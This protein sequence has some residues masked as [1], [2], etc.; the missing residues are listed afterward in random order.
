MKWNW[1]DFF[2]NHIAVKCFDDFITKSM[3][4]RIVPMS[5]KVKSILINR[6]NLAVHQPGEVVFYRIKEKS[7]I[8]KQLASNSKKL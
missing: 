2:Q 3:K 8:K 1:I 6:F 4:E 7:F 5:E